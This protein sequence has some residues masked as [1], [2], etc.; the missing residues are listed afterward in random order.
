MNNKLQKAFEAFD[1]Y[2]SRDPHTESV[3][4]KTYPKEL[5]YALRMTE[6]LNEYA[7]SSPE[8]LQLAA[9]CQHIG[10]WEIPRNSYPM[11]RKGYLQWRTAEKMHHVK[12]AEPMLQEAGYPQD[13]IEKVKALLLKKELATNP[14]TQMLEDVVCLVFIQ[15]YL[16]DF[17]AQHD[18]DKVVEIL[19][20]TIKKISARCLEEASKLKISERMQGLLL[21]AVGG[22]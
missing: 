21:K 17:A 10:R 6:K 18:D 2:N 5:L 3:N 4:G 7:P 12:I 9:R 14:D 1:A 8:Y 19:R 22:N 11:D 13:I 16:H 15:H 20:K